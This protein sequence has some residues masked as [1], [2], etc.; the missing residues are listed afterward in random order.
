MALLKYHNKLILLTRQF[1]RIYEQFS[2]HRVK[3]V[4][5]KKKRIEKKLESAVLQKLLTQ[6]GK[7]IYCGALTVH[8]ILIALKCKFKLSLC[9]FSFR[10]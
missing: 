1:I 9:F 6:R 4:E 3:V 2:N 10:H 8:R 5:N 7:S